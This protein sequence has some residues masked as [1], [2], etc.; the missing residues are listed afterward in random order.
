MMEIRLELTADAPFMASRA[1]LRVSGYGRGE[2]GHHPDADRS[3]R[4][5]RPAA[6]GRLHAAKWHRAPFRPAA[7]ALSRARNRRSPAGLSG[8][9]WRHRSFAEQ[10]RDRADGGEL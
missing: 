7:A 9:A 3:G 8:R 4:L 5:S 6:V 2:H 10:H 1:A